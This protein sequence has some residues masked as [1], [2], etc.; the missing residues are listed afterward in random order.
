MIAIIIT[1]KL[2]IPYQ[3]S[4]ACVVYISSHSHSTVEDFL[5]Q[6][7]DD[8]HFSKPSAQPVHHKY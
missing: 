7:A 2:K 4:Q 1:L 5:S 6:T 8:Y 3:K